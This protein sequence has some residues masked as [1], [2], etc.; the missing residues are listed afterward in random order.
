[1][2]EKRWSEREMLGQVAFF[3]R[4][5]NW[6]RPHLGMVGFNE[7]MPCHGHIGDRVLSHAVFYV[8]AELALILRPAQSPSPSSSSSLT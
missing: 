2:T 6:A 3:C 5:N 1:M 7:G 4:F 8:H